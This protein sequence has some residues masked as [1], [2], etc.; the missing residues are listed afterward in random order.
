MMNSWWFK[1]GGGYTRNERWTDFKG[2]VCLILVVAEFFYPLFVS[3]LQA[4][5]PA[6]TATQS[7]TVPNGN[8]GKLPFDPQITPQQA[9]E[10][11]R[12]LLGIMSKKEEADGQV[13]DLRDYLHA[14]QAAQG[15]RRGLLA[16]GHGFSAEIKN[17][18]ATMLSYNEDLKELG[19]QLT[20]QLEDLMNQIKEANGLL[21]CMTCQL[22]RISCTLN[23]V[24]SILCSLP[25]KIRRAKVR[26]FIFGF[27]I[28]LGLGIGLAGAGG[29]G[30]AA[31]AAFF[32]VVDDIS[33]PVPKDERRN[34]VVPR[35]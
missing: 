16:K 10:N 30:A 2:L 27:V 15:E 32:C 12:V 31:S 13:D 25:G 26:A 17:E 23:A 7:S 19:D 1:G 29:G 28:G 34:M 21:N 6:A 33:I 3:K 9:D 5:Q 4:Q 20:A 24:N 11:L 8:I 14:A 18:I 22:Q 35:R